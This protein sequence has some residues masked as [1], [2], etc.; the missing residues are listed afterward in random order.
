M[1]GGNNNRKKNINEEE[2]ALYCFCRQPYNRTMIS[3]EQCKRWYH[4]D[5]VGLTEKKAEEIENY[6]C[7][8]C[9]G[10]VDLLNRQKIRA[11]TAKIKTLE[12]ICLYPPCD[13][14]INNDSKNQSNYCCEACAK[15]DLE[16]LLILW[17]YIT[18]EMR[19]SRPPLEEPS[20]IDPSWRNLESFHA[21]MPPVPDVEVS[22]SFVPAVPYFPGSPNNYPTVI[23]QTNVMIST[24]TMSSPLSESS[25]LA[26]EQLS[27][28]L[29]ETPIRREHTLNMNINEEQK[30]KREPIE[31]SPDIESS[32]SME[33]ENIAINSLLNPVLN[34]HNS[35]NPSKMEVVH[36]ESMI[37]SENEN[38]EE[39]GES[40]NN[41]FKSQLESF[42]N[43]SKHPIVVKDQSLGDE[44]HVS[45]SDTVKVEENPLTENTTVGCVD[46]SES[47]DKMDAIENQTPTTVEVENTQTKEITSFTD[48]KSVNSL[49]NHVEVNEDNVNECEKNDSSKELIEFSVENAEET[50]TI[51]D[52]HDSSVV[53]E[54]VADIEDS[55]AL[56]DTKQID[57]H[58]ISSI[59]S[60]NTV[61]TEQ[62][63]DLTDK[64][65]EN[66][67]ETVTTTFEEVT[68]DTGVT[69][70]DVKTQNDDLIKE[71]QVVEDEMLV[72]D[73]V[74]QM[75]SS[76]IEKNEN[77]PEF[78]EENI[79]LNEIKTN[80]PFLDQHSAVINEMNSLLKQCE[81][82]EATY[83][84]QK[85]QIKDLKDYRDNLA[86]WIKNGPGN[87]HSVCG[88]PVNL[89]LGHYCVASPDCIDHQNWRASKVEK[90]EK[91]LS[92][93][94]DL[95][96]ELKNKGE[97]AWEEFQKLFLLNL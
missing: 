57:I 35:P 49:G 13:R 26:H 10:D 5:C 31:I 27:E 70:E 47:F 91:E 63:I 69:K 88:C 37:H 11:R 65:E 41:M 39:I 22:E 67:Q 75:E 23:G 56:E 32:K 24:E 40:P 85:K 9:S 38:R 66:V 4:I 61:K 30:M 51:V 76:I 29:L 64:N 3:C 52:M 34:E 48:E 50:K 68:M 53:N 82:L 54:E 19:N 16:D 60:S 8:S 21:E 84:F 1:K 17:G 86:N 45:D 80:K 2:E 46:T 36:S 96:K 7:A 6:I 97:I 77:S 79:I 55:S 81:D 83:T 59:N 42:V 25:L 89:K 93:L 58:V 73:K 94:K 92:E 78:K 14:P 18:P 12:K 62:K 44:N 20:H 90:I 95:E 43:V 87:D 15:K 33:I 74:M 72:D 71:A 28:S